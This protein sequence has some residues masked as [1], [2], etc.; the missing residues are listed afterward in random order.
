VP[1]CRKEKTLSDL[2][3]MGIINKT[4]RITSP[5][6]WQKIDQNIWD[7]YVLKLKQEGLSV[8]QMSRITGLNKG[9]VL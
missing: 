5:D 7:S 1:G 4:S 3:A 6:Q 9:V 2:D 8:G